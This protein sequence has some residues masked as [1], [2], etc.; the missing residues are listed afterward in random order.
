MRKWHRWLVVFFGVFIFWIALT[1]ALS[2]VAEWWPTGAPD[3]TA[4][5]RSAEPPPGF[6]CPDGWR[7]FPRVERHGFAGLEGFFHQIH[8]GA[9]FGPV[10]EAISFLSGLA[11]LFFAF[12]GLWMYLQMWRNRSR[13]GLSGKLFWK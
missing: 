5:R 9:Y 10:G 2:H 8:S 1:G 3:G 6:K 7:C 13:R 11:L 4:M 12:S